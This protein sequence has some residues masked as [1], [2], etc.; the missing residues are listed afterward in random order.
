MQFRFVTFGAVLSLILAVSGLSVPGLVT[1]AQAEDSITVPLIISAVQITGGVGKT[2]Q[3]FIELYNPNPAPINLNG[4]RLVKRSSIG[5][6]DSSIKSWTSDSWV[7]ARSFYLWVNITYTDIPAV[8]DVTTSSTL[9]DDNGVALRF[10]ALDTGEVIDSLSWG[11]TSNSFYSSGLGNPGAGESVVRTSLSEPRLYQIQTSTPRNS[12]IQFVP[13]IVPDLPPE[14]SPPTDPINIDPPL[15]TVPVEE[16]PTEP[17]TPEP[18]PLPETEPQP[19]AKTVVISEL[20][21]NP[22]G[23]DGGEE[24]VELHNFGSTTVNLDGWVLDDITPDQPLSTN[25][26]TIFNL[27]IEPGQYAAVTIPEGKFTM[28]NSSGDVITL[29]GQDQLVVN[30][31]VYAQ[32]APSGKSYSRVGEE[33]F[34]VTPSLGLQNIADTEDIEE[35]EDDT[36]QIPEPQVFPSISGLIIS[37]IYPAP[38]KGEQEFVELFNPTNQSINLSGGLLMIGNSKASLPVA[39]IA[40]EGYYLLRGENLDLSLANSGKRISL[41]QKRSAVTAE[42]TEV[43]FEVEYPKAVIG[44][45]YA[46]FEDN[47]LWTNTVTPNADNLL[48]QPLLKKPSVAVSVSESVSQKQAKAKVTT[49]SKSSSTKTKSATVKKAAGKTKPESNFT[50]KGIKKDASLKSQA[51]DEKPKPTGAAGAIAIA[52]ASLSAGGLAVYRYGMGGAMPF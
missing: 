28:N 15:E 19:L 16:L 6:S 49:K 9:A 39:S 48:T 34:W 24:V 22:T 32:T 31:V 25:S 7:P 37:E 52:V 20:L 38:K 47:Y 50:T 40:S 36:N 35:P 23:A 10:G 46:K 42:N 26:F 29:F 33:W 3:D 43:V 44:Q 8:P 18:Q 14:E 13:E 41:I 5:T 12:S 2:A 17:V 30:S 21:P 27:S 1:T 45:S 4:Y 51:G 11:T